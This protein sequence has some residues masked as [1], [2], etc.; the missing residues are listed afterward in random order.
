[1]L[2][3]APG[4]VTQEAG[5]W[6]PPRTWISDAS[7]QRQQGKVVVGPGAGDTR[8]RGLVASLNM[9]TREIVTT[10]A[11]MGL[12]SGPWPVREEAGGWWLP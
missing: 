5:E 9:H 1:M 6:W 10:A 7:S 3:S 11:M 8:A 2:S 12:S 4:P